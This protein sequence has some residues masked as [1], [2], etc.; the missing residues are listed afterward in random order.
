MIRKREFGHLVKWVNERERVR[1]AKE[2]GAPKPWTNN[3][4]LRQYRFCNVVRADDKVSQWLINNWYVPHKNDINMLS[5]IAT[6]RF[7]NMISSLEAIG[8]PTG[9]LKPWLKRSKRILRNLKKKG[10]IFNAAYM[11][12]GNNGIDKVACVMDYTVKPLDDLATKIPTHSMKEAWEMLVPR[13]GMGSFM[14]GQIVAD[15]RW[16]MDGEWKDRH[17]WA[18][19]GPGSQRGLNRLHHRDLLTII[20]QEEFERELTEVTKL[21]KKEIP[22]PLKRR[23]EAIDYQNCLCEYDKYRR[24][25]LGQ[26]RPKQRYPGHGE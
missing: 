12:R 18:P 5:A 15:M 23:M 7:F 17:K 10:P 20:S 19:K 26:G 11:V 24:A 4:I 8:F 2:C 16:A 3:P 21:L 6:A 9:L 25:Q 1:I 22:R 14:A 13:F